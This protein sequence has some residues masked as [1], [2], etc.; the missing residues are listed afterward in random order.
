[1][2]SYNDSCHPLASRFR[3]HVTDPALP[4]VG[5][6]SAHLRD[7]MRFVVCPDIDSAWDDLRLYAAL[8]HSVAAYRERLALFQSRVAIFEAPERLTESVFE[9]ILWTRLQ[10][11][12]DKDARH[13]QDDGPRV[14]RDPDSAQFSLSLGGIDNIGT[15]KTRPE[16]SKGWST[17]GR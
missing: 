8:L 13:G 6:K 7:Q 15:A 9:A 5:A 4:G 10:S 16:G 14:N 2:A 11:L 3:S 17:V 12:A 1:M